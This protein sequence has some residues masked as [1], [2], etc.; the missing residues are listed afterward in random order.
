MLL[1]SHVLLFTNLHANVFV[2]NP[3]LSAVELSHIN[4][5]GDAVF[6]SPSTSP[7]SDDARSCISCCV[8]LETF[9]FEI[10]SPKEPSVE[11]YILENLR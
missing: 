9:L 5:I 6:S 7:S 8:N 10:E 3:L 4:S 1:F 2:Y 11:S